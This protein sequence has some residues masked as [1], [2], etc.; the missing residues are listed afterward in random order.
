MSPGFSALHT[1]HFWPA[2]SAAPAAVLGSGVVHPARSATIVIRTKAAAA[3]P[4][5]ATDDGCF[6]FMLFS[7]RLADPAVA[8]GDDGDLF[9]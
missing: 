8:A 4:R 3:L 2:I 9:L 1:V 6:E 5:L 7:N